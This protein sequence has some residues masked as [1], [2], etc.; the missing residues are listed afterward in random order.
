MLVETPRGHL[1]GFD[2]DVIG[3]ADDER[4]GFVS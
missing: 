1:I 2:N 4:K 3:Q